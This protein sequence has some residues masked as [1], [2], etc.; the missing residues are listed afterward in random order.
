YFRMQLGAAASAKL[1]GF[2][3]GGG[4]EAIGEMVGNNQDDTWLVGAYGFARVPILGLIAIQAALEYYNSLHP[5]ADLNA[6]FI[7]PGVEVSFIGFRVGV[8][9]RIAITD[10]AKALGLGRASLNFNAGYSW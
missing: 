10:D 4:L 9:T 8:G 1:L 7:T 2:E 5:S 3:V 6:L